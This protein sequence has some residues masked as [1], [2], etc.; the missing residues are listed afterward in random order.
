MDGCEMVGWI[1]LRPCVLTRATGAGRKP[2]LDDRGEVMFA[3]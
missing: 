1:V 3:F 2:S